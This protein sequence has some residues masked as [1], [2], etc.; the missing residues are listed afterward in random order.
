MDPTNTK[1]LNE[2]LSHHSNETQITTSTTTTIRKKREPL[3]LCYSPNEIEVGID[4]DH[5]ATILALR[6]G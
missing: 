2:T 4:D 1:I 3:K 5:H 6:F